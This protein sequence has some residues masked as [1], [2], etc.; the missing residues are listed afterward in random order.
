MRALGDGFWG[1][2]LRTFLGPSLL[3]LLAVLFDLMTR[4]RIHR[5]YVVAVPLIFG[6]ELAAAAIYHNPA[7]PP[8][9]R[10]LVGL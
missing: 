6:A 9:A 5:V 4:G 10:T 3:I 1:M 8:V 2:F 7:W